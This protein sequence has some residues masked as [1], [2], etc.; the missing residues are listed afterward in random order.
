[1]TD[2]LE[3]IAILYSCFYVT[4]SLLIAIGEYRFRR[5]KLPDELPSVSVVVC[6]RNEEKSIRRCLESLIRLDYPEDKLE[7]IVLDDESE[8]STRSILE[9]Y[10]NQYEF[11][12]ALST[13]NE[14]KNLPAKQ[15]PLNQGI[16]ESSGEIILITDADCAVKPGWV[17]GHVAA[18][19]DEKV[20]IAGGITSISINSNSFPSKL[21]NF[22][23]ISKLTIANGCAGLGFPLTIMGNNM[24][25]KRDAYIACG[26]FDTIGPSIV[27]DV[28]LM[29]A[30]VNYT[31]FKLAWIFDF[32][33]I[34]VSTS[35]NNIRTFIEQRLRMFNII[36]KAPIVSKILICI[37][38]L[39]SYLCIFALIN[40]V[41]Y[42]YVFIMICISWAAAYYIILLPLKCIIKFN[43]FIF[44][45]YLIFQFFYGNL[46]ILYR[47]FGIK[48]IEWKGREYKLSN[49][50]K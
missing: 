10:A 26:G 5:Q 20:G 15:R 31:D 18:Y 3:M 29:Y 49:L 36:K 47:I 48:T 28:D 21:Q 14:P 46:I 16:R 41:N 13:E 11:I 30:I 7:I 34:V 44:F 19:I 42:H 27:E 25:F 22:D 12:T 23:Q 2:L 35:H 45:P 38:I 24:S 50:L 1:M 6:A 9:E 39:M 4:V 37:E 33:G 32:N 40:I 43:L 17:K 8:D